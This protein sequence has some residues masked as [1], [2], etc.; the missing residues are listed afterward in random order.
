MERIESKNSSPCP[1]PE[2]SAYIDGELSAGSEI[3]LETHVTG[4][5]V[6]TDDLNLQKGFLNAL[7]RS[8]EDEKKI[9]LPENF[10]RAVVANAESRV[11]GLRRPHEWR[12]AAFI[13]AA[14]VVFSLFALGSNAEGT[15]AATTTV[16]EKVF[17]VVASAG[18]FVYDAAL[19][20]TIVFRSLLSKFV[21]ESAAGV[22][23]LLIVFVLSLYIFSRLV[24]RFHRT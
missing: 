6:C 16:L 10:T 18:H 20:S 4:C 23:F 24:V 17:A 7:D 15:F 5:R 2:I 12:N 8:L 1:L 3:D 22:T 21:L 9:E 19:G 11:S 14:L 13:C